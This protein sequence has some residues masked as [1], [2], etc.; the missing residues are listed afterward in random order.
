MPSAQTKF[1][2]RKNRKRTPVSVRIEYSNSGGCYG[3]ANEWIDRVEIKLVHENPDPESS[4]S[5]LSIFLTLDETERM[6]ANLQ[7]RL[8]AQRENVR[9]RNEG[10]NV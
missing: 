4:D 7:Q 3:P 9:Q 8:N 10:R 1:L 2:L 5:T 6:I